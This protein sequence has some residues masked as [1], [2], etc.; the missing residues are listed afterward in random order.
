MP[1]GDLQVV[2]AL[3]EL[4]IEITNSTPF[5]PQGK[6]K[7]ERFLG[8]LKKQIPFRFK[9][10]EVR[11]IEEANEVL[12]KWIEYY[13]NRIHREIGCTPME[14]IKENGYGV[15]RKSDLRKVDLHTIFSY[16]YYRKV[17]RDN[18]VKFNGDVCQLRSGIKYKSY[19]G[20]TAEIRY[21]PDKFLRVFIDGKLV[22]MF[23]L[24]NKSIL[25]K[26]AVL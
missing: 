18:T 9:R 20:K 14:R 6:G 7:I 23:N 16:R 8:T 11:T 5:E 13:N 25:G 1:E 24:N 10:Y 26:V 17:N 22:Q 2:R 19:S 12:R 4:G 3:K 21:I 15:F